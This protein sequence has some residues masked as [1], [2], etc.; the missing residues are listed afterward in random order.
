MRGIHF[1]A[2]LALVGAAAFTFESWLLGSVAWIYG[3]GAGVE[4]LPAHLALSQGDRLFS[5]WAPFAAG[6]IDRL[7]FWGNADPFNIEPLLIAAFPVWLANGMHRLLQYWIAIFF[8]ARVAREQLALDDRWAGVAGILH[9]SFSYFTFGEMLA[10]PAVPMLVWL[11]VKIRDSGLGLWAAALVGLAFS[12]FTTFTHSVPYLAFFG[13][14]WIAIVRRD[15]STRMMGVYVVFFLSMVVGDAPQLAA[16]LLNA[17]LSHRG[18][19]PAE[20]VTLSVDSLLYR[21]L[22]FDYFNQDPI[23]KIVTRDLP[24]PALIVGALLA[25]R[26]RRS[27]QP[28]AQVA[29]LFLRLFL[30]YLLLSQR[31]AW[32]GI[33][34][35]VA[36]ALPWVRGIYMGRFFTLPAS[37]LVGA[38][39]AATLFL[40]SRELGGGRPARLILPAVTAAFVLFM[41][42]RPRVFLFYRVGV[43]G[44]G[45][46]DYRV[47]ALEDLRR[48]QSE[49]FRV[50]SVLPLQPA[51]AYAQGFETA[52][53]WAN[54][55][56]R[57]YRELWLQ[58]L[59]P[60]F[61]NLP[62]AKQI[63]A[64]DEGRPQDHYI[65]LGADLVT[66]NVGLLPGEYPETALR[67][68]FDVDRRFDLNLLG[69]LN[70]RYVL[71]ELPLKSTRLRLVH[72]PDPAPSVAQARDWATGW[73]SP[74]REP[75]GRNVAEGAATAWRDLRAGLDRR[76]HGKDVFI[77]ELLTF[78][79][80]FRFASVVLFTPDGAST[81]K[82]LDSLDSPS[83]A[84]T[85]VVEESDRPP[86]GL[87]GAECATPPRMIRQTSDEIEIATE[88]DAK[89]LLVAA[90]NWSPYWRAWV[91]GEPAH[92]LRV[93][94][95]HIGIGIPHGQRRIRLVYAPPYSPATW[96]A[97][98]MTRV[99]R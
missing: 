23:L 38:G 34:N 89:S 62:G 19:F 42:I 27:D 86:E 98:A 20:T 47:A 96:N 45:Q 16:A 40:A 37:F 58:V 60:L 18:A 54:L 2:I 10:F 70:V 49:P 13:L 26:A 65:F 68:G 74:A 92:V 44:W 73:F 7:A 52:D 5:F 56:S 72:R 88:C 1:H 17:P 61:A 8:A 21:Q 64:P 31:W 35:L 63:F 15:L 32:V 33:Q 11:L 69:L 77:Y 41:L 48:S 83:L 30:V 24:L 36:E 94:H 95:A 29:Q 82:I 81:L 55:Y 78:V 75:S 9:G 90:M 59:Q 57:Y 39:L 97:P 99:G 53:G 3:Y 50:A 91:D 76:L 12:T 84:R 79:P 46:A 43:D 4:T 14:L 67:E 51:Y 93:N 66:P 6:G 22:Q 28:V 80:R 85:A 25:W 87:N 71:S